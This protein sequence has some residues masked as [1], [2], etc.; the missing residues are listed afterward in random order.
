MF[1]FERQLVAS[2]RSALRLDSAFSHGRAGTGGS[3]SQARGPR[4]GLDEAS[5]GV[6]R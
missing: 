4:E 5:A 2:A 3:P 6:A 1:L